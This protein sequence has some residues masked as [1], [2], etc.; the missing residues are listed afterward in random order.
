[1]LEN[2]LAQLNGELKE[3]EQTLKALNGRLEAGESL[4]NSLL[5]TVKGVAKLLSKRKH[6]HSVSLLFIYLVK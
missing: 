4:T 5:T 2:R 3:D 6:P 1:M